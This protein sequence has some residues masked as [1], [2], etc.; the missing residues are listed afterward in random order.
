M[1]IL[2]WRSRNWNQIKSVAARLR[3]AFQQETKGEYA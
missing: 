3:L 2:D 1:V